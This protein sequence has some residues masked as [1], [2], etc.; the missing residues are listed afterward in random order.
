MKVWKNLNQIATLDGVHNKDGRHLQPADIG[1]ITNGSIVFDDSEIIWIGSTSKLPSEFK[2]LDS[3]DLSG[4]CLTPEL[5]DSHTHLV[6]AGDRSEEYTMRLNGADYQDIAKA[7][8]G[9]LSSVKATQQ[10]SRE[11]L[12]N[13][14]RPRIQKM[15]SLGVGTI[16]IKSGYGLTVEHEQILSE[17]I[18]ELKKEFFPQVQ[19]IRTMMAAHAVEKSFSTSSQ[20]LESVVIPL[21]KNLSAKNL[22]DIID[23]F[24]EDGYFNSQDVSKLGALASELSLGF[25][26]HADEFNDNKGAA[27]ACSLNAL[28]ADHLLAISDQGIEAI[29][30][31]KTVATLLPGTGLFLGKPS[32]PGRKLLDSG[33]KVA[34]AT[35]FNPGS[36]HFDQ[37]CTLAAISAMQY[38]MNISELW[39]SITY[40]ASHALGLNEQGAL[41]VGFKPRFT[42]FKAP[43]LS[44]ITYHWGHN[45]CVPL[46][47]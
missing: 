43:S 12:L 44:H 47:Q 25:K 11:E 29:S 18:N 20:Y 8:G 21:I 41:I 46:P 24:H 30:K 33:A 28:S 39:A 37:L 17:V 26:T 15:K 19:I 7:G 34:I 42:L 23:I 40:N 1:I 38:K 32:A 4:H 2:A 13:L 5:V 22:I 14:S 10:A 3:I 31:S 6:F 35:D 36:C 27:L 9:I 16:E 45:F